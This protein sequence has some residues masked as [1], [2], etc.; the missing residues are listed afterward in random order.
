M[1]QTDGKTIEWFDKNFFHVKATIQ[2]HPGKLKNFNAVT[3]HLAKTP[4]EHETEEGHK[5]VADYII[6]QI[7]KQYENIEVVHQ[8]HS[9]LNDM[10]IHSPKELK[11]LTDPNTNPYKLNW[12]YGGNIYW[13]E[14]VG[15]DWR[16]CTHTVAGRP[17]DKP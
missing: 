13:L 9:T 14:E 6:S 2:T 16:S 15:Y 10:I 8:K 3:K 12:E 11:E 1:P 7:H 4:C 5:C 17:S